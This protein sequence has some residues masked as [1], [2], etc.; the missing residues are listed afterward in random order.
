VFGYVLRDS[1]DGKR[2]FDLLKD[3]REHIVSVELSGP[4][5]NAVTV[6]KVID[7]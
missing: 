1:P 6:T 4:H 7:P 5:P 3:G 2:I